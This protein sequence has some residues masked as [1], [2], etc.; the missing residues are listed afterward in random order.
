MFAESAPLL[1]SANC[2]LVCVPCILI[3][4]PCVHG[5]PDRHACTH[6]SIII[7]QVGG[8]SQWY[9]GLVP[10]PHPAKEGDIELSI[11]L[12]LS[13]ITWSHLL[14]HKPIPIYAHDCWACRTKNQC[15][16][17]QTLSLLRVGSGNEISDIHKDRKSSVT[18]LLKPKSYNTKYMYMYMH[19]YWSA[20]EHIPHTHCV[21]SGLY[22]CTLWL[23]CY[24]LATFLFCTA[25][26]VRLQLNDSM[27]FELEHV[28]S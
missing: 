16:C 8:H 1:N 12:V 4:V 14:Q 3:R 5:R 10:R 2:P 13:T 22:M 19:K 15:Q 28:Q 25:A 9:P 23:C 18:Q 17:P 20:P 6:D 24:C 21:H 27:T 11:F 7:S 26:L